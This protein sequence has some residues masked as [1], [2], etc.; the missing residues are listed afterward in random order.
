MTTHRR[1]RMH[2]GLVDAGDG[3]PSWQLVLDGGAVERRRVHETLCTLADGSFGTRGTPECETEEDRPLV[4]AAGVYDTSAPSQLLP[5]PRWTRVG[6]SDAGAEGA[7]QRGVGTPDGHPDDSGDADDLVRRILDLR[8]GVLVHETTTG[9]RGTRFACLARPGTVVLRVQTPSTTLGAGPPLIAPDGP[10]A[11]LLAGEDGEVSWMVR[12][13]GGRIAAVAHTRQTAGADGDTLDRLAGYAAGRAALDVARQRLAEARALGFDRLLAEQRAAWSSRWGEAE[14]SIPDDPDLQRAIRFALFHLMS[15]VA[16]TGEAAVG[17]RGLSGPAYAGHV[18]WDADVFV[19]P[20]LAATHPTAAR[21]ML[22]YRLRR[23]DAARRRA[24]E[25][26]YR[27]TRFP[28]ESAGDGSEVTPTEATSFDGRTVPILTGQLEEHIVADVAWAASHYVDWTGDEVFL[29]GEGRPLLVETAR[30]WASRIEVDADGTGH[31][32]GVIGPDEYHERVDDNV[33]TNVMARWNLRRAAALVSDDPVDVR[34]QEVGTAEAAG[35][36]R[37]A[38]RLVDGY[39]P[40]VGCHEQFIGYWGLEPLEVADVGP[41]PVAA[42]AVLGRERVA[43][44]RIVKQADVVMAHHLVPGEMR[45][46]TLAADLDR[47]LPYTAHGSSLSPAIHAAALARAGRPDD[48]LGWLRLACRLDF[49]DLTGTSAGGLHLATMGGVWQAIAYGFAGL[50][51]V[52]GRLHVA[53]ALPHAWRRLGITVRTGGSRVVFDLTGTT[54]DVDVM[55]GPV[56]LALPDGSEQTIVGRASF[57][58]GG[59]RW[60]K[61]D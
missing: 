35:W 6:S 60:R 22:E 47:Y 12:E 38:D 33:F 41:P 4:V 48:A 57:S 36:R 30:Y 31:I 53:P 40:A 25:L 46:G 56:R 7:G 55:P 61:V 5:G 28:W 20:F 37:L 9:I 52:A 19:L 49:D 16:D 24:A 17:A 18:F 43:R 32:R 45:A 1:D 58:S 8:S 21:A 27:G 2:D 14:V 23:L 51:P 3:G 59:G 10:R 26:G 13:D 44:T 11:R 50:R 42:D 39:D 29:E 34:Q 15:S 54:I